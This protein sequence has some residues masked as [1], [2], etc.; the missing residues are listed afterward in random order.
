[1]AAKGFV[2]HRG[3]DRAEFSARVER[4]GYRW[5]FVAEN[6]AAGESSARAVARSWM[7]SAGHRRNMLSAEA[8]QIGVGHAFV[9]NDRGPMSYRHYWVAV[10]ARA[11]Y[12]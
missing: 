7:A 2:S 10:F 4:A 1:M 11:K 12:R 9:D 6:I 8:R 3:S 5:S